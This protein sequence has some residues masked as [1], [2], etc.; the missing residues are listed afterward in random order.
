MTGIPWLVPVP[1]K[2]NE[3]R[4]LKRQPERL[5]QTVD[6]AV[7]GFLIDNLRRFFKSDWV[8]DIR[9]KKENE[10]EITATT[11]EESRKNNFSSH[12]RTP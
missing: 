12:N 8:V 9:K 1:R 4:S 2:V 5:D 11:K 10:N 6:G 7:M 3:K